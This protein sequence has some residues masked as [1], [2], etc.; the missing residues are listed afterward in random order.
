VT[1]SGQRFVNTSDL[2]IEFGTQV[3]AGGEKRW[4][5][6]PEP[7]YADHPDS[8]FVV[9]E[10]VEQRHRLNIQ[11]QQIGRLMCER[12]QLWREIEVVRGLLSRVEETT[13]DDPVKADIDR[14]IDHLLNGRTTKDQRRGL[15]SATERAERVRPDSDVAVGR[16]LR[17]GFWELGRA[18]R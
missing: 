10:A 16:A 3:A 9:G 6:P 12:D 7:S 15:N 17:W 11:Q 1:Q 4:F 8:A 2:A 13:T 5:D 18:P 14:T